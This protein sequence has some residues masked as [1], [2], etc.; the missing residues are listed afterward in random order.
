MKVFECIL[1][2]GQNVKKIVIPALH[3]KSLVNDYDGKGEFIKVKEVTQDYPISIPKVIEA[4]QLSDF[5]ETEIRI[6][7]IALDKALEN[8]VQ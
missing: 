1:E 8:K 2:D 7:T 5:G 4:L 6:I 3:R